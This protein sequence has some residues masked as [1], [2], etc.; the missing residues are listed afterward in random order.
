MDPSYRAPQIL[1]PTWLFYGVYSAPDLG[2][3]WG[4]GDNLRMLAAGSKLRGLGQAGVAQ[5]RTGGWS[6]L[7]PL[8]LL[9]LA[10]WRSGCGAPY[11]LLAS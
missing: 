6:T 9:G 5:P 2:A 7:S 1:P 10:R 4:E 8:P 3:I 11:S